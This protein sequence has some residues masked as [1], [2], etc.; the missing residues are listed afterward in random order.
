[1]NHNEKMKK[2]LREYGY[3]EEAIPRIM[4]EI[5]SMSYDRVKKLILPYNDI[6]ADKN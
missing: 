6:T 2:L 1:M 4:Q 5:S 3:P